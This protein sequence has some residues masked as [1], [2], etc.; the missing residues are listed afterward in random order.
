MHTIVFIK[1]KNTGIIQFICL[2][3]ILV[4]IILL[5]GT[6]FAEE[7]I[8][9]NKNLNIGS[10]SLGDITYGNGLYVAVG[11]DGSIVTS[12]DTVNWAPRISGVKDSLSHVVWN[13]KLFVVVGY[14]GIILTSQDGIQW[15]R[16]DSGVSQFNLFDVIWDGSQFVAAGGLVN[17][18]IILSSPDG[19]TWTTRFSNDNRGWFQSITSNGNVL[20]TAGWDSSK[21]KDII[22]TSEDMKDWLR[23]ETDTTEGIY[24]ITWNGKIFAATDYNGAISTSSDGKQWTTKLLDNAFSLNNIFWDGKQFIA[25]GWRGPI[26]TSTDGVEWR[27]IGSYEGISSIIKHDDKYIAVSGYSVIKSDDCINWTANTIGVTASLYGAAYSG[28]AYV[29]VGMSGTILYSADGEQWIKANSTTGE[30]LNDVIWSGSMFIAVGSS[31]TILESPDGIKW[32]KIEPVI[33]EGINKVVSNDKIIIAVGDS[34]QILKSF[35]GVIW[36]AKSVEDVPNTYYNDVI[37]DGKEFVAVGTNRNGCPMGLRAKSYD[38]TDWVIEYVEKSYSEV[39]SIA[40]DGKKYIAAGN[41]LY[42]SYSADSWVKINYGDNYAFNSIIWDGKRFVA[43][44]GVNYSSENGIKWTKNELNTYK[45]IH[46][47]ALCGDRYIAVGDLGTILTGKIKNIVNLG[48]VNDDGKVNSADRSLL[49]R[50][51]LGMVDNIDISN[52]DMNGDGK[53]NSRDYSMLLNAILEK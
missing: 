2:A 24:D 7:N 12:T 22:Y 23:S 13:G 25:S 53:I 40:Y 21:S 11:G 1:K 45:M 6:V 38:G 36:Y 4:L 31:G 39:Y 27:R 51:I 47:V 30:N 9:W 20:V 43:I 19:V 41:Y 42:E 8:V 44:G 14:S 52:A 10:N 26:F 46:K 3:C 15:K 34:G 33:K 5:N 37:W 35:D 48:D 50:Y 17:S 16:S 32:T 29:T 28:K 49:K 18:G